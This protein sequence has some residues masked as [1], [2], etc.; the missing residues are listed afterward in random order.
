MQPSVVAVRYCQRPVWQGEATMTRCCHYLRAH[1]SNSGCCK[2]HNCP[3]ELTCGNSPGVATNGFASFTP[4]ACSLTV[5]V[6]IGATDVVV[7]DSVADLATPWV[8]STQPRRAHLC[9]ALGVATNCF[10]GLQRNRL[11]FL[12]PTLLLL[13]RLRWLQLLLLLTLQQNG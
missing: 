6:G 12:L 5:G 8:S 9:V 3:K 10:A 4:Q 2:M 7:T 1:N 13:L 11:A